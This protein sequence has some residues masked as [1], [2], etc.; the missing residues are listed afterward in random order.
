MINSVRSIAAIRHARQSISM[1]A[2]PNRVYVIAA[3]FA[4]LCSIL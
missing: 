2:R 4:A 1:R 3:A